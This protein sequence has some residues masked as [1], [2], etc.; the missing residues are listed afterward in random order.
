MGHKLVL[1]SLPPCACGQ[2]PFMCGDKSD[3]K[4]AA[5][6]SGKKASQFFFMLFSALLVGLASE[7]TS[8]VCFSKSFWPT[9]MPFRPWANITESWPTSL[10][11]G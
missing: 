8:L 6:Q 5:K 9:F 11:T 7:T 10:K 4:E 1:D 3:W 2:W